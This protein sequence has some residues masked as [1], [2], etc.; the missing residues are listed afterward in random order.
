MSSRDCGT[1]GYPASHNLKGEDYC[2]DCYLAAVDYF[3]VEDDDD[4]GDSFDGFD[5]DD[6][7]S[8]ADHP[9]YDYMHNRSVYGWEGY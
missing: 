4:A 6:T 3:E 9:M 7:P 2:E 8:L 5:R 1:C